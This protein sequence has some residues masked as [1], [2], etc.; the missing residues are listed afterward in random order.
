MN[1]KEKYYFLEAEFNNSGY[2]LIKTGK[3]KD[4][5]EIFK[6][7]TKY[8]P[9]SSNAYDS[10]GEAYMKANENEQAIENY[11]KSLILNP[12]NENAKEMLKKICE[13]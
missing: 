1:D 5:I 3:L 9:H 8:Y 4:A 2:E 11:K 12:N 13:K 7:V 10:L 6:L